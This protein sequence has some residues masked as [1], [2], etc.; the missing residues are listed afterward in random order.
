MFL[1]LICRRFLHYGA[2]ID[3]LLSRAYLRLSCRPTI[4]TTVHCS[5]SNRAFIQRLIKQSPQRRLLR[6]GTFKKPWFPG[7]IF[8]ILSF[9]SSD[10]RSFVPQSTQQPWLNGCRS[11]RDPVLTVSRLTTQFNTMC[12]FGNNAWLL[13]HSDTHSLTSRPSS[14]TVGDSGWP[15][16]CLSSPLLPFLWQWHLIQLNVATTTPLFYVVHPLSFGSS[17]VT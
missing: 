14:M 10:G 2:L 15:L 13:T 9:L 6:V 7:D 16:Y 17:L 8:E 11:L 3:A 4:I 12:G 1:A 5:R